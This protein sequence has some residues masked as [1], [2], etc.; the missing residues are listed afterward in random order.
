MAERE[1]HFQRSMWAE[2]GGGSGFCCNQQKVGHRTA[3]LSGPWKKSLDSV[4]TYI[5]RGPTVYQLWSQ[6]LNSFN[7]GLKG[8]HRR[9][10][11]IGGC[12][13]QLPE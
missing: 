7:C 12:K 3:L 13:P 9:R 8:L 1:L 2:G 6:S 5:Y 10:W 11:E 4:L